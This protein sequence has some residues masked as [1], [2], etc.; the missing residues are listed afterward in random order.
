MADFV[1]K[2]GGVGASEAETQELSAAAGQELAVGL[3]L[4][5]M[6]PT[7]VLMLP[8]ARWRVGGVLS[9]LPAE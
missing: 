6:G 7:K 5:R 4:V 3:W 9:L 8:V 2:A 1:V